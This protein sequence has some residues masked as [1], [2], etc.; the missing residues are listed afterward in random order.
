VLVEW[1]PDRI[2]VEAIEAR[3][4]V[5]RESFR[6]GEE[7]LPQE[8]FLAL[9]PR[10][11]CVRSVAFGSSEAV[12]H[13]ELSEAHAGDLDL[14]GL[15]PA[16]LDMAT[17]YAFS[18]ID[19]ADADNRLFVPL[20]YGRVRLTRR[21]PRQLLSHVRLRTA[22]GEGVGVLDATLADEQGCVMAEIEGY[23]VKAVEPRVLKSTRKTGTAAGT[24]PLERA[25]EHGILPDEGFDT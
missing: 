1:A 2:D 16:L 5:R 12:A 22:S 24:S 15:H 13:L 3:C 4:D 25:V 19:G 14:Y 20:S 23:V 17:G 11:K 18:L 21:L 6:P 7:L 9:G 8:R 10:W